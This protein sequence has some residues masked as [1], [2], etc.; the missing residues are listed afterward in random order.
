MG[1]SRR[2]DTK[3]SFMCL[4]LSMVIL[5]TIRLVTNA[6]QLFFRAGLFRILQRTDFL[7]RSDSAKGDDRNIIAARGT[8]ELRDGIDNRL[9]QSAGRQPLVVAKRADEALF[10]E[11][12]AVIDARF[13]DAIGVEN[14]QVIGAQFHHRFGAVP[15]AK[16]AEHGGGGIEL[17]DAARLAE[18][19]GRDMPAVDIAELA[20]AVVIE[21]EEEGGES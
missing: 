3:S 2:S 12:F 5:L 9:H 4:S 21:P 17:L 19:H 13:R 1:T 11:L 15:F 14:Q 6:P 20:R 10:T 18:Q 8:A 16:S 7:G